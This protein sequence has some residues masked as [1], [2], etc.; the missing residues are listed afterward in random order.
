[1]QQNL[2]NNVQEHKFE[3]FYTPISATASLISAV[4]NGDFEFSAMLDL[5]NGDEVMIT[6]KFQGNQV[7]SNEITGYVVGA[8][9]ET[10][11]PLW[12]LLSE[13]E[14]QQCTISAVSVSNDLG[15]TGELFNAASQ[16]RAAEVEKMI[17]DAIRG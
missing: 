17:L 9:L 8:R 2:C 7:D 6:G 10:V 16:T 3:G 11:S 12:A 14:Q 5:P 15:I 13:R 1:M 4:T